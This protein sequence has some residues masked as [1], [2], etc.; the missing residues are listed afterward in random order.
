MV[1]LHTDLQFHAL[2]FGVIGLLV[3]YCTVNALGNYRSKRRV[4]N[5]CSMAYQQFW[6]IVTEVGP[7]IT[8]ELGVSHHV[9]KF[10]HSHTSDEWEI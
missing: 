10:P 3:S 1:W 4:F 6:E 8:V 7:D 9:S 5:T 2:V